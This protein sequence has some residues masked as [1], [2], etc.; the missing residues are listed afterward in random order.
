[1]KKILILTADLLVNFALYAQ[2][3]NAQFD[4]VFS[5]L[6]KEN[7]FTGNVLIAE[8]GKPIF[9]KSYGK[10]FR[11]KGLDLNNESVFELASVSK[12]FTAM[13][14]MLLK[15]Q[16]KLDYTDSLRKF[17]PGLPYQNISIRQLLNHTSGLPDYLALAETDWDN[18]K[19]MTNALMIRLL[20]EKK[21]PVL[22][23]P[24]EKWAYS[25]TGYALLGSIIE[26]ASGQSFKDFMA[27]Q[28]FQPLGMNRTQVYHKRMENRSIDNYAY[29]YV[30]DDSLGYIMADSAAKLAAMVYCMDGIYGDGIINSTTSDLLK[31]DQALY[32]EKLVSKQMMQEAFTPAPLNNG[33][34]YNYG[35]GWLLM[36]SKDFGSYTM[37]SGGWPGY[38]TWIERHP[39]SNKT[40]IL[41]ANAGA[42]NG[43]IKAIRNILFGLEEKP[44][45]EMKV[46][47]PVL[48]QYTGTYVFENKDSLV[49][50]IQDGKLTA[51]GAG[52]KTHNLYAESQDLFFRKDRD[53]KMQFVRDKN[54]NV[55]SL[56]IIRE[57]PSIEAIKVK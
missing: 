28:I 27:Q 54:G 13:G 12:Q 7:K 37:H 50:K 40:I 41:L 23:L 44:L 42:A 25:N 51:E 26:K 3:R 1:M 45:V 22:F 34:T 20:A 15:K 5:A 29:G 46:E 8:N 10:A 53:N 6:Y 14:I 48:G 30:K 33:R 43:K 24:G 18:K 4:S 55:S 38:A 47:E 2:E 19:I 17:F 35:F 36:H 11:E 49:I 39:Q 57:G 56:A 32:T 16:G 21:P 31:W 9:Q 52:Q